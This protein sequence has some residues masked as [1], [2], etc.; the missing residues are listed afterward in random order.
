MRKQIANGRSTPGAAQK[1]D[2][3]LSVDAPP[4]GKKKKVNKQPSR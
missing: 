1:N 3:P 4:P 2:S